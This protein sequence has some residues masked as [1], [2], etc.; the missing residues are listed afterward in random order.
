MTMQ[1]SEII[2]W[3]LRITGIFSII[4]FVIKRLLKNV[5]SDDIKVIRLTLK[6]AIKEEF[7]F[8]KIYFFGN[9]SNEITIIQGARY[10][11]RQLKVYNCIYKKNKLKKGKLL[12]ARNNIL[13]DEA[14]FLK[15]YYGC[16]MPNYIIEIKNH[17]FE[18]ANIVLAENGFNGN[19]DYKKG[20]EYKKT[21][22]SIIYKTLI[23]N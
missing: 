4:Q 2:D 7:N 1:I 18:V 14:T 13:P 20:I 23:G 8:K 19:V 10:P 6:E 9:D 22:I 16:A 5:W 15:L 21:F 3:I 12:Y 11:I 17:N